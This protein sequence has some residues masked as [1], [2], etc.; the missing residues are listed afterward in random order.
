MCVQSGHTLRG[1]GAGP[2]PALGVA[3]AYPRSRCPQISQRY[4]RPS[5][6]RSIRIL[7]SRSWVWRVG[8][9]R[10]MNLEG[11]HPIAEISS[12]NGTRLKRKEPLCGNDRH[13]RHVK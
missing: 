10:T 5:S 11:G 2:G 12:M 4:T 8:I 1:A 13:L 3:A 7:R 6:C 9:M